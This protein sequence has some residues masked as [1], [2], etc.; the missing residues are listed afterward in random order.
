WA[1]AFVVVGA[2]ILV[3]FVVATRRV[4]QPTL[5][6]ADDAADDEDE[7][8]YDDDDEAYDE[9]EDGDDE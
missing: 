1:L 5:V 8:E 4:G 7:D 9:D 2:L 3:P 6:R